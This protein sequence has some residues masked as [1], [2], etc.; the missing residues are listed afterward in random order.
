MIP[1]H[2]PCVR[3]LKVTDNASK[4]QKLRFAI[5]SHFL[6]NDKILIAVPSTEAA[7]Y[8][9]QFLWKAPEESFLPHAIINFPTKERIAITTS[10]ANV[11]QAPI[12][13]NLLPT[14]HPNPAGVTLIYELLDLTS[15][16]KEAISLQ[17]QSAYANLGYLIEGES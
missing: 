5:E 15:K 10:N 3:F 14:L 6:K 9:D 13:I 1:T 11:N 4:L 12:L 16:E 8:I 7:A 17:K 2:F